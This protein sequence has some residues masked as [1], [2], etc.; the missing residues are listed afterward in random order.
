[1]NLRS[2]S[3]LWAY[4]SRCSYRPMFWGPLKAPGRSGVNGL[5]YIYTFMYTII[6]Y[7]FLIGSVYSY[8]NFQ[9]IVV[10]I[11]A[12]LILTTNDIMESIQWGNTF[13]FKIAIIH[14][15]SC[16]GFHYDLLLFSYKSLFY[17]YS[18]IIDVYNVFLYD[19]W[20]K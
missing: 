12:N 10:R 6:F 4:I 1:M 19:L 11:A 17:D 13:L 7:S 3:G 15:Y 8:N 5:L 2:K 16:I 18:L 9:Q 14:V 20:I